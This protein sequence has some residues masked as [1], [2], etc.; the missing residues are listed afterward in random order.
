MIT[1][2]FFISL[3]GVAS[4]N[5]ETNQSFP[6]TNQTKMNYEDRFHNTSKMQTPNMAL[7]IFDC[8]DPIP[9]GLYSPRTLKACE[10]SKKKEIK[11]VERKVKVL[12]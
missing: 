3:F 10:I 9:L 7:K 8:R 4:E 12:K 2:W 5:G 1:I 11:M 6:Q